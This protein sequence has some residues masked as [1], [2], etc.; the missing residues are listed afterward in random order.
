MSK[1]PLNAPPKTISEE[2]K[3]EFTNNGDSL[4]VYSYK[5]NTTIDPKF[6]I[7]SVKDM[8]KNIELAIKKESFHYKITDK[9]LYEA[10]EEFPIRNQSIL[11]IGSTSCAYESICIAY[12]G[13]PTTIEYRKIT[14]EHPDVKT[15]TVDEYER[16][17]IVFDSAFSISSFEH[18][19]LGRYG[20]PLDPNG[21]IL[22]M[23]NTKKMIKKDGLLFLAV[24]IGADI[25][26]FN[27]HRVYGKK[28][29][30]R[31]IEGWEIIKSF[32]FNEIYFDEIPDKNKYRQ[33]I[34]VLK[35]I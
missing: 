26:A 32:G 4:F 15:I 30:K 12:G 17:P 13:L 21:D 27:E 18:S 10:L 9:F 33:P 31:L 3:K 6:N 28:R 25:I 29:F 19:G 20:D 2:Q 16:N 22:S 5:N 11:V 23:Q 35:N 34:F 8:D 14:N 7:F 1:K 24:P